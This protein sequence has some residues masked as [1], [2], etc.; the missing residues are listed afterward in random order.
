LC[1]G[2][3]DAPGAAATSGGRAHGPKAAA[4]WIDR[5]NKGDG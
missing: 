2:G 3:V 5:A 1:R 4:L